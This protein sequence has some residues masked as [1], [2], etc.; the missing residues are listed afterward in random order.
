MDK[1]ATAKRVAV[2][3]PEAQRLVAIGHRLLKSVHDRPY[4]A[5]VVEGAGRAQ[6]DCQVDPD[7]DGFNFVHRTGR[8]VQCGRRQ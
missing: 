4:N 5:S 1:T 6:S 8:G 3:G 7:P 2:A